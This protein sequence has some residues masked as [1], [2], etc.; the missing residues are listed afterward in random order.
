MRRLWPRVVVVLPALVV[1]LWLVFGDDPSDSTAARLDASVVR[2]FVKGPQGMSSGTG[3]VVNRD[4]TVVTNFHVVKAHL[5]RGWTVS[6]EDRLAGGEEHLPAELVQAFPGE[7][8]AILH[9]AGLDRPPVTFPGPDEAAPANGV[10]IFALG[11]PGAADRLGPQDQASLVPGIVSRTFEGP[12]Q[13]GAPSL[14]IIQ[15][16]APVNPGNSGG[17]LADRCGRVIGINTQREARVVRGPGGIPLVTDPI[18]GVFYAASAALLTEKLSGLDIVF[19]EASSPCSTGV[20][21]TLRRSPDTVIVLGT[22]VLSIAALGLV[23]RPRTAVLIV[24]NCGNAI[25]ACAQAV[26]RALRSVS[27]NGN[28]RVEITVTTGPPP[29]DADRLVEHDAAH[30]AA[31]T[32]PSADGDQEPASPDPVSPRCRQPAGS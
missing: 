26:E 32:E 19:Q 13:P 18:Q 25:N 7:D 1:G 27:T 22:I 2:V 17:P 5:R 23:Y 31:G 8:L 4:G 15:H 28:R 20:L 9:V 6:V 3:F 16:T 11:F 12:W 21:A 30:D 14:R 10:E 24:V 29:T